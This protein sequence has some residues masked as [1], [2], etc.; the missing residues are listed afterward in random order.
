MLSKAKICASDLVKLVVKMVLFFLQHRMEVTTSF[1]VGVD[2]DHFLK[3]LPAFSKNN[4]N[5]AL[6]MIMPVSRVL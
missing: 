6:I 1:T 2:I 3:C 4:S 5:G